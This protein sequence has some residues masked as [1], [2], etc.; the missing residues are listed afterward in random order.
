MNR[1][2]IL[3]FSLGSLWA[4]PGP[5]QTSSSSPL[6]Y[7]HNGAATLV[8]A[9]GCLVVIS[10][11]N[12]DSTR[13]S[14]EPAQGEKDVL[15]FSPP[16][17]GAF[18]IFCGVPEDERSDMWIHFKVD[19]ASNFRPAVECRSE[20]SLSPL[21]QLCRQAKNNGAPRRHGIHGRCTETAISLL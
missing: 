11:T 17:T 21:A 19:P 9:E 5:A 16:L 6:V 15:R 14:P 2:G 12:L 7:N 13:H 10:F 1:W 20:L 4:I 3:L 8:I 18:R